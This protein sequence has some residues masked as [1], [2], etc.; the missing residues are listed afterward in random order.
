MAAKTYWQG[1]VCDTD[2][3][4]EAIRAWFAGMADGLIG[5]IKASILCRI[6]DDRELKIAALFT[7]PDGTPV[8]LVRTKGRTF[9]ITI[10]AP[11]KAPW[12][13]T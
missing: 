12:L 4:R 3:D 6:A 8:E 1:V 10:K 7:K 9:T 2:R 13:R 11:S 5:P